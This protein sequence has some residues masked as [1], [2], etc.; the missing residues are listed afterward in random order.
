MERKIPKIPNIG[1]HRT[2]IHKSI[3]RYKLKEMDKKGSR[4]KALS[5]YK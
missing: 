3:L 5:K 1:E 4:T 2:P